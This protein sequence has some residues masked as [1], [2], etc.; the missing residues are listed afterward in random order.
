MD[1]VLIP[2]KSTG[3]GG[4]LKYLKILSNKM[5]AQEQNMSCAAACIRQI[6]KD[7]GIDITE[8][9]VRQIAETTEEFGT[10]IDNIGPALKEVFKNNEIHFGHANMPQLTG[11]EIAEILS[12]NNSWIAVVKPTNAIEHTIIVDKIVGKN[13]YIRDPWP[14]E[15]ISKTAKGVE[16]IVDI[17]DFIISWERV[18]QYFARIK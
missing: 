7:N 15:G 3:T 5:F 12:K 9:A 10:F 6:A 2:L 16:A 17:D 14:I 18:G 13:V 1:E 11:K 8:K 4:A